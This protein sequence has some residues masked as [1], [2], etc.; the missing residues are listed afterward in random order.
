MVLMIRLLWRERECESGNP[1]SGL[2]EQVGIA[3]SLQDKGLLILVVTQKKSLTSSVESDGRDDLA[4]VQNASWIHCRFEQA[5]GVHCT[6]SK[7]LS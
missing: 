1:I 2:T 4:R 7:L 3:T 5:H 6:I